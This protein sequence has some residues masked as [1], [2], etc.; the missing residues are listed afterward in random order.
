MKKQFPPEFS[1]L[2]QQYKDTAAGLGDDHPIAR[3]LLMLAIQTAPA[4]S[5][6]EMHDMARD[7]GLMPEPFG[8]DDTGRKF[9]RLDDMAAKLG[10]TPAEAEQHMEQIQADAQALGLD[11]A[12]VAKDAGDLHRMH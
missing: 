2:M 9:Y 11:N 3:R 1:A 6:R 10:I 8:C 4:W 12:V 5:A 7:M